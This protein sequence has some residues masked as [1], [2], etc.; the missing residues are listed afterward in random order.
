MMKAVFETEFFKD[1]I[2]NVDFWYTTSDDNSLDFVH[3]VSHYVE[4]LTG[5]INWEPRFVTWACP[6]CPDDYKEA[7]CVSD[8]KYCAMRKNSNLRISGAELLH[9]DLRQFCLHSLTKD[10]ESSGIFFGAKELAMSKLINSKA[11]APQAIYFEY[12]KR[13]HELYE[14]RISEEESEKLMD[15]FGI[16]FGKIQECVNET[17]EGPNH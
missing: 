3:G 17:F 2:V 16:D 10:H 6:M 5:V 11:L 12:L 13:A 14:T 8:G 7:N 15:N 4:K 1:N 9:E